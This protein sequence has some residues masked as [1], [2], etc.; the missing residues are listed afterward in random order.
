M[1]ET[2]CSKLHS[3]SLGII[4]RWAE[5]KSCCNHGF[6]ICK[7]CICQS[8][9]CSCMSTCYLLNRFNFYMNAKSFYLHLLESNLAFLLRRF[10]FES[11]IIRIIYISVKSVCYI[12]VNIYSKGLN[13]FHKSDLLS[14]DFVLYLYFYVHSICLIWKIAISNLLELKY[15]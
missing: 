4:F 12:S 2:C 11:Y 1:S 14:K 3:L 13:V 9:V 15:S 6:E 5:E 7:S 8:L 10:A